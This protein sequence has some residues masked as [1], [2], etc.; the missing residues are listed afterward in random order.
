MFLLVEAKRSIKHGLLFRRTGHQ[1]SHIWLLRCRF[2]D[3]KFLPGVDQFG[4]I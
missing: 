1:Q 4:E 3:F 2:D